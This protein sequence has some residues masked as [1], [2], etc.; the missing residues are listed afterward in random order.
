MAVASVS[1]VPSSHTFCLD[2][3]RE[4]L[5]KRVSVFTYRVWYSPYLR[6]VYCTSGVQF[7]FQ[8]NPN[9]AGRSLHVEW[10]WEAWNRNTARPSLYFIGSNT[11]DICSISRRALHQIARSEIFRSSSQ[12]HKY[13]TQMGLENFEAGD[14][15]VWSETKTCPHVYQKDCMVGIAR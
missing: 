11:H 15:V 13:R 5:L 12:S 10:A 9:H 3:L 1:I 8:E 6:V 7:T 4:M 2:L 14:T